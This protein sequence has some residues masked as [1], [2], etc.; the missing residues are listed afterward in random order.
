MKTG[1]VVIQKS[2]GT[3]MCVRSVEGNKITCRWFTGNKLN[4]QTYDD[5][6]L[7]KKEDQ[8]GTPQVPGVITT[9]GESSPASGSTCVNS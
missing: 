6:E 5:F 9:S 7:T 8:T 1:D 3:K 4:E 2:T